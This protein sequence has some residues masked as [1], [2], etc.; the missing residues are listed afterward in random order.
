M[1]FDMFYFYMDMKKK[2]KKVCL[3]D[4]PLIYFIFI[5]SLK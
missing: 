4:F 1:I 2:F 3:D 5:F